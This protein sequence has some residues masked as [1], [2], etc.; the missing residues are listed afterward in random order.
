MSL[1]TLAKIDAVPVLVVVVRPTRTEFVLANSTFLKKISHSSQALS[2]SRIRGSFNGSDI[3]REYAGIKNQP[4]NFETLFAIHQEF[5]WEENVERLVQAT[6]SIVAT[7]RPFSPT[8]G[9]REAIL[10]APALAAL[11]IGNPDYARLKQELVDI[12][13]ERSRQILE[14]ARVENVKR[15]GDLIE[16]AM[17][18]R[19]SLH[20]LGD[21]VRNLAGEVELQL[22][23][24]T[25]LM[26][27]ASNPKAYNVDKA[28]EALSQ[29]NA[30]IAFCLVGIHIER[31]TVTCST[32]SVFDR[33]VMAATRIQPHWAGRNSR[34]VTQ[35]TGD[36]S[37][38]FAPDYREE[39][40][41]A[42]GV[43]FLEKLLNL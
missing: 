41:V 14:Y 20:D 17:T 26:D 5:T 43:Q 39:I 42:E 28:L 9:Q 32:V 11:L 13:A 1:S 35:L 38:V 3:V 18:G 15:R 40:D 31:K 22:E 19:S 6:D 29:G 27:R 36:F 2:T 8:V 25:K 37:R 16:Q 7:G 34:G 33:T 21:I 12:V 10:R 23:I 30:V 24:K 4:E